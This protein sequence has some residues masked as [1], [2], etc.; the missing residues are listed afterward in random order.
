MQAFHVSNDTLKLDIWIGRTKIYL[1]NVNIIEN[2][3]QVP[4]WVAS[5][6]KKVIEMY[7]VGNLGVNEKKFSR[8]ML[9]SFVTLLPILTV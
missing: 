4:V 2:S 9:Q 6:I 7:F 1:E 5:T 3:K 8:L